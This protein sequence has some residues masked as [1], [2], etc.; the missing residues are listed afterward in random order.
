MGEEEGEEA[1]QYQIGWRRRR[2]EVVAGEEGPGSRRERAEGGEGGSLDW[3][4][5]AGEQTCLVGMEGE[6]GAQRR[7]LWRGAEVVGRLDPGLEEGGEEG[8]S[9]GVG[10]GEG[11]RRRHRL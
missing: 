1:R 4:E 2:G 9:C 10:E 3:E 11:G 5:E 7:E 8:L 6:A